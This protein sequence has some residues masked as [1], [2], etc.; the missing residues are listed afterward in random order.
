MKLFKMIGQILTINEQ[1][2]KLPAPS[3]ILPTTNKN[4]SLSEL[5]HTYNEKNISVVNMSEKP[6]YYKNNQSFSSNEQKFDKPK[7]S[8]TKSKDVEINS[9]YVLFA[10][11][12]EKILTLCNNE[13]IEMK[14]YGISHPDKNH[15]KSKKAVYFLNDLIKKKKIFFDT[16]SVA[17]NTEYKL[18]LD[19]EKTTSVN[20]ILI[21]ENLH[22]SIMTNIEEI[23]KT[24][25]IPTEK[26]EIPKK[27]DLK[28]DLPKGIF[29]K[30]ESAPYLFDKSNSIS[31]VVT[32]LNNGQEEQFWSIDLKRAIAD[33]QKGDLIQ[34][35]NLG[36]QLVT[37]EVPIKDS[38]NKVVKY[39]SKQVRRNTWEVIVLE[40]NLTKENIQ[41]PP[42][43]DSINTLE[44]CYGLFALTANSFSCMHK[45]QKQNYFLDGI[46][47]NHLADSKK[48]SVKSFLNQKIS[49]KVIY[50][51][52]N[53]DSK[54]VIYE[55]KD[56][57]LSIN[58]QIL[59]FKDYKNENL[60][61]PINSNNN[62][63]SN[64]GDSYDIFEDFDKDN[65]NTNEDVSKSDDNDWANDSLP[66][67][68]LKIGG[69]SISSVSSTGP[70]KKLSFGKK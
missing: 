42:T 2:I 17:N 1:E 66:T 7:Y 34:L 67:T 48:E 68:P 46:E 16:V 20:N 44:N 53:E 23:N 47:L 29:V 62:N 38:N 64:L 55:N 5:I 59:S 33:V 22:L 3:P 31:F 52:V 49:K 18:Y 65:E 8:N 63:S 25:I 27:N 15:N 40:K 9:C 51:K 10:V 14:L 12:G 32:I 24:Y 43:L 69:K 61:T 4:Q 21:Q 54:V 11:S 35:E 26:K 28:S 36:Q 6:K 57:K 13:K 58:E 41:P 56:S 45:N 37:V 30:G 70:R 39:E 19:K 60:N 50:L